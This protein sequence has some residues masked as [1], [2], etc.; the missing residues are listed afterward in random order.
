MAFDG[1]GVVAS[2]F[3]VAGG[4]GK[5]DVGSKEVDNQLIGSV[6]NIV[7]VNMTNKPKL[8]IMIKYHQK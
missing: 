5:Y 7:C 2:V 1:G 3:V 4:V 6:M 8:K